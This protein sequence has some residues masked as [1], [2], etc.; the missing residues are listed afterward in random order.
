MKNPIRRA[1]ALTAIGTT[2]L[3]LSTA[4][5]ARAAEPPVVADAP[6]GVYCG[7]QSAPPR[8]ISPATP[9]DCD[10]KVKRI[11]SALGTRLFYASVHADG[12]TITVTFHM[13]NAAGQPATAPVPV[14]IR[15]VSHVD[16][17][18]AGGPASDSATNG[19]DF[20]PV[21][22]TTAVIVITEECGQTDIKAVFIENSQDQGR[23]GG[24][25]IHNTLTCDV[26]SPTT[27]AT[28]TATTT[29]VSVSGVSTVP[30]TTA[31]A[32]TVGSGVS[33]TNAR[34]TDTLPATGSDDSK[35]R[36]EILAGVIALGLVLV[37][38]GR[39]RVAA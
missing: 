18:G 1:L 22:A 5:V 11:V 35:Q 25:T 34:V 10:T 24:P 30:G 21:G 26:V 28:T 23:L 19:P 29:A 8:A 15:V 38:V 36:A 27:V 3:T 4:G 13:L 39:R 7:G 14:P 20:I 37:I 17:S 16:D 6:S 9:W 33:V 12:A 2:A 31:S 32:G